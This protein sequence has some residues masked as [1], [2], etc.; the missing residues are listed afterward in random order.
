M[1]SEQNNADNANNIDN[2]NNLD[3]VILECVEE[4]SKLRV[5][6]K[7]NRYLIGSNCQFPRDL[8]VKGRMFKVPKEHVKLIT[9][10]GKYFYSIKNKSVIEIIENDDDNNEINNLLLKNT[11]I[12]ED[13]TILECSVCLCSEKDTVFIPCGHFHTC[14][15]CSKMVS[16]CPICRI[17]ITNR[18]HKNLFD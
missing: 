11:K 14:S 15:E 10:R 8:R 2:T 16:T 9:M 12:F 7:S 6:M 17:S 13:E 4:G 3:Y 1:A 5:K 18:I